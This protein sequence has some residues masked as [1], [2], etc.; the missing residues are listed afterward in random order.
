M[1]GL[2]LFAVAYL[3]AFRS[4]SHFSLGE[5]GIVVFWPADGIFLGA[6]VISRVKRW[7]LIFVAGALVELGHAHF[8]STNAAAQVVALSL[9]NPFEALLGAALLRHFLK[10]HYVGDLSKAVVFFTL[11]VAV[12]TGGLGAL[13]GVLAYQKVFPDLDVLSSWQTWWLSETLGLMFITPLILGLFSGRPI[14]LPQAKSRWLESFLFLVGF[15][16][17]L[18]LS[19]WMI[20]GGHLSILQLP[21]L[22]IPFLLWLSFRYSARMVSVA[23]FAVAFIAIEATNQGRGFVAMANAPLDFQVLVLQAFLFTVYVSIMFTSAALRDAEVERKANRQA[24]A[25][26]AQT[27]RLRLAGETASGVAHDFNNYLSIVR[28]YA[29]LLGTVDSEKSRQSYREK[30]ITSLDRCVALSRR[31]QRLGSREGHGEP[32]QVVDLN[33]LVLSSQGILKNA[34]G[35]GRSELEVET[36]DG[37]LLILANALQVEELLLNLVVNA[38]DAMLVKGVCRVAVSR[39]EVDADQALELIHGSPGHYAC[40]EVEDTGAGM[41]PDVQQQ[42]FEPFFTT[43]GDAGTGLGMA[44]V[45]GIAK[46]HHACLGVESSLGVGTTIRVLFPLAQ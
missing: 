9:A 27:D 13:A 17:C 30:M 12:F 39:V 31:L 24:E 26:L 45:F 29:D 3:L 41:S 42:L 18:Y 7:P 6:L 33:Q 23:F 16:S 32:R 22:C 15:S 14:T 2:G 4:V 25:M 20:P 19:C 11:L 38:R 46:S 43:K 44:M 1:A 8:L 34:M 40:L 5:N 36:P 10:K 35:Q 37:P 28:G 21:S